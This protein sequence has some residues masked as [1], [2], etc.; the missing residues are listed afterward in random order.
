MRSLPSAIEPFCPERHPSS[1]R[2]QPIV[3]NAPRITAGRALWASVV[4]VWWYPGLRAPGPPMPVGNPARCPSCGAEGRRAALP[5]QRAWIPRVRVRR[6][7]AAPPPHTSATAQDLRGL[8]EEPLAQVG[9]RHRPEPLHRCQVGDAGG[10][11][12]AVVWLVWKG[13]AARCG[14]R[15]SSTTPRAGAR[16]PLGVVGH[17]RGWCGG[18]PGRWDVRHPHRYRRP[19]WRVSGGVAVTDLSGQSPSH[20]RDPP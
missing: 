3:G 14:G 7:P 11:Q 1:A 15:P 20:P 17:W 4:G 10:R 19:S 9:D 18:P 5:R 16:R 8:S 6:S 2:C 12:R 13:S